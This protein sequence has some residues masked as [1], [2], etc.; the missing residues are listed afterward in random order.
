MEEKQRHLCEVTVA[1][2]N[3]EI[4]DVEAAVERGRKFV[5]LQQ[6]RDQWSSSS[7]LAKA[8]AGILFNAYQSTKRLDY[9]NEAITTFRDL[10]KIPAQIR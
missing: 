4:T 3:G 8:F 7:E 5:P 1:I 2:I 6:S 10:R 9:L